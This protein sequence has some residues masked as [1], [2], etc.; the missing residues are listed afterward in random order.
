MRKK[1]KAIFIIAFGVGTLLVAKMSVK[2]EERS[3]NRIYIYGLASV[4]GELDKY[5]DI[6]LPGA[7]F[8]DI[9]SFYAGERVSGKTIKMQP[10]HDFNYYIGV[11]TN[12][13]E[14]EEGLYV[15]GY[16]DLNS[17]A[18]QRWLAKLRVKRLIERKQL[19]SV[20]E[21]WNHNLVVKIDE[22]LDLLENFGGL[23]VGYNIKN[24]YKENGFRYISDLYMHEISIT[25]NP[26]N[27]SAFFKFRSEN[28]SKFGSKFRCSSF[29]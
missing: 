27:A 14:T 19:I 25:E 23:S 3:L 16:I 26:A 9:R 20:I 11:W 5:N 22:A 13:K 1:I 4:F 2:A 29:L 6:I 10:E 12:F 21:F 8:E 7:F 18:T 17:P 28:S 24:G 15:E